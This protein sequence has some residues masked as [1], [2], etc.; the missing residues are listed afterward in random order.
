MVN[1]LTTSCNKQDIKEADGTVDIQGG[2]QKIHKRAPKDWI[3]AVWYD[4]PKVYHDKYPNHFIGLGQCENL[5]SSNVITFAA[6]EAIDGLCKKI[7]IQLEIVSTDIKIQYSNKYDTEVIE[8][9]SRKVETFCSQD[10]FYCWEGEHIA[11]NDIPRIVL[12]QIGCQKNSQ[13]NYD[14]IVLARLS[15]KD[16]INDINRTLEVK[17]KDLYDLLRK[18]SEEMNM[19]SDN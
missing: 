14:A 15:Y 17:D 7:R 13:G 2:R 16:F 19:E 5:D 3:E 10:F 8:E 4:Y 11:L 6:C 12:T 18:A 9:F 1:C